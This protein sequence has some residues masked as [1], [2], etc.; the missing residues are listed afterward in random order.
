MLELERVTDF[1]GCWMRLGYSPPFIPQEAVKAHLMIV[2][3]GK[4]SIRQLRSSFLAL[5]C[6]TLYEI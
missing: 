3:D 4:F 1:P 2:A 6:A 5:F